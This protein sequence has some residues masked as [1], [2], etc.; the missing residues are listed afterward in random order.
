M[1]KPSGKVVW[2]A[3]EVEQELPSYIP[4]PKSSRDLEEAWRNQ[5]SVGAL[6]RVVNAMTQRKIPSHI[7][8]LMRD[9]YDSFPGHVTLVRAGDMALYAGTE[10]IEEHVADKMKIR[11]Q[12]HVFIINGGKYVVTDF[13]NI[14]PVI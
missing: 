11:V 6:W 13:L 14:E 10:R 3:K 9:L 4:S 2:K 8:Y 12:R 1:R 5:L 7:P